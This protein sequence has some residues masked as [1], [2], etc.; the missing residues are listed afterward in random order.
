MYEVRRE[1][2]GGRKRVLHRNLLLPIG[3]LREF[4]KERTPPKPA[5][6]TT[7]VPKP[8]PQRRVK[9]TSD[10]QS[11][12]STPSTPN[13]NNNYSDT[14]DDELY[15]VRTKSS[16]H[17]DA[18]ENLDGQGDVGHHTSL[19]D[20]QGDMNGQ[21]PELEEDASHSGHESTEDSGSGGAEGHDEPTEA[22]DTDVGSHE[23]RDEE[24]DDAAPDTAPE[25]DKTEAD[26]QEVRR[27]TRER[28]KP[29]WLRSGEFVQSQQHIQPDWSERALFL[30]SMMSHEGC[31]GMEAEIVKAMLNVV[32][33]K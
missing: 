22:E 21:A 31:K 26:H 8:A 23:H 6:R 24:A 14:D 15:V 18:E 19:G 27:S 25:A 33:H 2:G 10:T 29:A 1:D 30:Q 20:D 3:H 5:P 16:H 4:D 7:T 28:K 9:A 13:N 12:D 32:M 17:T 11:A